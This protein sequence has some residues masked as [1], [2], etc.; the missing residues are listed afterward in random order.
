MSLH[1]RRLAVTVAV[2]A[3]LVLGALV[4]AVGQDSPAQSPSPTISPAASASPS[5]GA[6]PAPGAVVA[7]CVEPEASAAPV[8]DEALS[9]PEEFRIALFNGVWEGIRD[10]YVDPETNGLDWEAIGDEYALLVIATDNAHEVYELLR[11]M[12]ALLD[13]PFTAF[14]AP[15]DLGDPEAPVDPTYAGIGALVDSGA[16]E[17]DE[18]GLRILYVFDG[19]SAQDAGLGPRDRIV[20][21][22]GDPCARIAD[23]RGPAGTPVDLTVISPGQD[24]R[25]VTL[26]RRRIDPLILPEARRLETAPGVGYLRVIALSGEETVDA[27]EQALTRLAR[28]PLNGLI[29]DLRGSNQGAPGVILEFLRAFVTGEVGAF[30]FRTGSEPIEIEPNDLADEYAGVPVVVLVDEDTEADAEQLAAILQDQGRAVVVGTQTSGQTHGAQTV[31]FADGSLL[32]VVTFGFQLPDGR[33]LEGQGVTP[34]VQVSGDW[35]DYPEAE[36]PG[37][38]AALE[39]IETGTT[40]A[41]PAEGATPSPMASPS[42]AG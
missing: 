15:E 13:D 33:T 20:A 22:N 10:A 23:I 5:A 6:S 2:S 16:T 42:P 17:G 36:D 39:V 31:D 12:V 38:L 4:P 25:V 21:V 35:L 19:S 14:F 26:E 28:E 3:S 40:P 1:I 9:I 27:I 18:D 8:V 24:P 34:D 32:Q 41:S 30:H 7:A 11:E 29:V 37:I